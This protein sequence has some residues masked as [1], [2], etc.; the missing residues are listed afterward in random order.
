MSHTAGR[1]RDGQGVIFKLL[2][3]SAQIILIY[4]YLLGA[5]T[6]VLGIYDF[7]RFLL[8]SEWRDS[9][10]LVHGLLQATEM[11]LLVPVPIVIGV[12]VY[13]LVLDL[14]HR[15]ETEISKGKRSYSIAKTFLVG[16]IITLSGTAMLDLIVTGRATLEVLLGGAAMVLSL[17]AYVFVTNKTT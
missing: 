17:S 12:I 16:I 8:Q 13:D 9:Q 6:F 3:R 2:E 5:L 7:G 11:L 10:K 1:A 4:A 14:A 15:D